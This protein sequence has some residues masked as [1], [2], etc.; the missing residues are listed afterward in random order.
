MALT[1]LT[2]SPLMTRSPEL[3]S[4]ALDAI[5][6]DQ[7]RRIRL[8]ALHC[9][10]EASHGVIGVSGLLVGI[11][12]AHGMTDRFIAWLR[13][14]EVDLL[15]PRA[16]TLCDAAYTE[17]YGTVTIARPARDD[18]DL[19][20]MAEFAGRAQA[21]RCRIRVGGQVL[22]S[23]ALVSPRLVLTAA[24][25]IDALTT[26]DPA[27]R[28]SLEIVAADGNRY[29]ARVAWSLPFH[30]SEPAGNLPP[31]EAMD[32]HPDVA[33]LRLD[34]PLGRLF[35]QMALPERLPDWTGPGLFAL[36]HFP[37]G[38]QRGLSTGRIQRDGPDDIRQFHTVN[39]EGGSSGGPGFDRDFTF[40]GLHQGRWQA[41]R[42]IVPYARFAQHPEFRAEL[43]N[44]RPPAH[45]WSLDGS[46]EGHIIIGRAA[47]FDP[48]VVI[49]EGCAPNLRGIWTK[50]MDT[51]RSEGL[52]FGFRLLDAFLSAHDLAQDRIRLTTGAETDDLIAHLHAQVFGADGDLAAH[53]GVASG[54][55][56]SVAT[57]A[58]RAQALA[59]QLQARAT[60]RGRP[61]WVYFENPPSGLSQDAQIQFEH[62]IDALTR[63]ADLRLVLAGFE[64]YDLAPLQFSHPDEARH[65]SARG[66]AVEYLGHFRR[67]DLVATVRAI[68]DDLDLDW[69]QEM[70]GRVVARALR[71][72]PALAAETYATEHLPSVSAALRDELRRELAAP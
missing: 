59:D 47:F 44:D 13:A 41:F 55:T 32:T 30:D 9:M 64:T 58:E 51:S 68:S 54:Q 23:G 52:G 50:R 40:L 60:E 11:L 57:D 34:Q 15:P 1:A 36:I 33:L 18:F 22:G 45:L 28:P 72:V 48:L 69:G 3:V 67:S 6:A 42:R 62:L 35:G 29:T 70:R 37:D 8:E 46:P 17:D 53:P 49:I 56:T 20:R 66:L 16:D 26:A 21:F 39:T 65:A 27:N 71:R 5:Y 14:R 63:R 12:R 4:D 61:L 19:L 25:V 43:A 38:Q 2:L 10:A 24:H 31:P 7:P